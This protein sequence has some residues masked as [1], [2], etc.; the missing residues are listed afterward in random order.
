M[1]SLRVLNL[2]VALSTVLISV[3]AYGDPKPGETPP[4]ESIVTEN[5]V[6]MVSFEEYESLL[7]RIEALE[8]SAKEADDPPEEACIDFKEV[9]VLAKPTQKWSGRIHFDIWPF[10]N[11]DTPLPNFLETGDPAV[12]PRDFVG[13]RRLRFGVEGQVTETMEYKIE[14]EFADPSSLAFKDAYLGWTEL[15]YLHTVKLGNQKRPYG[16]DHLNSSR[17]NVFLERPMVVEAYNQDA[18]RLGL[19]SEGVSPDEFWNWRYG[20]F[21]MDDL[22][23]VGGQRTDN[24]QP[25]VAGRLANTLWYDEVSGGRG[26]FHWAVSGSAA[27]PGGGPDGRFLTR[28]EARTAGRWFD[29][30]NMNATSYQLV[31]LESVLN[32]GAFSIVGEY[33]RSFVQQQGGNNLSFEGGYVYVAYW[34]TGEH[35]PWDRESGTLGRTK[36][37]E[38]FFRVRTCDG[39]IARGRGAWQVAGRYSHGDFNDDAVAGGIGDT[40]TAGLNWWWTPYSRMQFNYIYGNIN[41]RVAAGAPDTDGHYHLLGTRFMVDF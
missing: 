1:R 37:H 34:L 3:V 20:V 8:S 2:A 23:Q 24:Y 35:T 14:M 21:L 15:P 17:Y 25:E 33:M 27:F 41:N 16:L 29:T 5:P 22:A 19:M 10:P 39:G 30:G 4:F 26:Y 36:P 12:G 11:N 40:F 18:R 31:G 32:V 13:Y 9:D 38:N 6:G 7:K 28:P